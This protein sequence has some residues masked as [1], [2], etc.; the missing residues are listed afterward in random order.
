[1]Q[2]S[3]ANHKYMY[4][5]KLHHVLA[6]VRVDLRKL[7]REMK[8]VTN[9]ETHEGIYKVLNFTA[10]SLLQEVIIVIFFSYFVRA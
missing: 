10:F 8:S 7:L 5:C 1:M 4:K 3:S 2:L 9:K 6:N